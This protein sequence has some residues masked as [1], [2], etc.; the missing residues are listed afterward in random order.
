M[1][2]SRQSESN[3]NEQLAFSL[4]T[5]P[6]VIQPP[7]HSPELILVDSI[8]E[9]FDYDNPRKRKHPVNP[10]EC[11]QVVVSPPKPKLDTSAELDSYCCSIC[12]EPWTTTGIHRLVSLKCGHL[13]GENCID[14]WLR[15]SAQTSERK[16]PQC[17]RLAAFKDIRPIYATKLVAV[18]NSELASAQKQVESEKANTIQA[19]KSETNMA[20]KYQLS[21]AECERLK[22]Q[23]LE[24]EGKLQNKQIINDESDSQESEMDLVS[25]KDDSKME[26]AVSKIKELSLSSSGGCRILE[27]SSSLGMILVSRPSTSLLFRGCGLAKISTRDLKEYQFVPVHSNVIR[28]VKFC[29]NKEDLL[30]SVSTD[31]TAKLTSII[32]NLNVSSYVL[33]A[34]SWACSWDI[35]D[36]NY[37]YAAL[38]NGKIEQFDIRLTNS[39]VKTLSIGVSKPITSICSVPPANVGGILVATIGGCYFLEKH[40]VDNFTSL[41][42]PD[43]TGNCTSVT[44][45]HENA[46]FLASFRP[47]LTMPM[48]RHVV[49]E[50]SR[51]NLPS[52]ATD[53]LIVST[54]LHQFTGGSSQSALSRSQLFTPVSRPSRLCIAFGDESTRSLEICDTSNSKKLTCYTSKAVVDVKSYFNTIAALTDE[55]LF[56]YELK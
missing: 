3:E 42:L 1:A 2:S 29:P 18:D 43:L 19:K 56:I 55:K 30:L 17:K 32:T 47:T 35:E 38:N 8:D 23:V 12:Y 39:C 14:K 49:C 20:L 16:C 37:F 53:T 54:H 34:Q 44:Y 28:D 52:Q 45:D 22:L 6:L 9:D 27:I 4:E 25:C 48:T 41:C 31:K 40:N 26:L 33:S 15:Q 13:F 11:S 50:F 24:L 10:I 36:P 5:Y 21:R 51:Y 7:D 46:K